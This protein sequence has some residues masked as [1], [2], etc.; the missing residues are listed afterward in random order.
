M[1]VAKS[2]MHK[3]LSLQSLYQRPPPMWNDRAYY[4]HFGDAFIENTGL[5]GGSIYNS[6]RVLSLVY[7]QMLSEQRA[8]LNDFGDD[9]YKKCERVRETFENAIPMF[10]KVR[11]MFVGGY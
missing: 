9:D 10:R 3:Q 7:N 4:A 1:F 6:V 11:D 5:E 2:Q 8:W